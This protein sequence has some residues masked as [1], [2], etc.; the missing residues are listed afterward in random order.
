[1]E[2]DPYLVSALTTAAHASMAEASMLGR[3]GKLAE[4]QQVLT[5][6]GSWLT[7]RY[8]LYEK[9]RDVDPGTLQ[10]LQGFARMFSAEAHSERMRWHTVAGQTAPA[11]QEKKLAEENFE[12]AWQFLQRDSVN[13]WEFLIRRAAHRIQTQTFQE[14]LEDL[15]ITTQ[16]NNLSVPAHMWHAHARGAR[17]LVEIAL[18][19]AD[20][21][22]AAGWSRKGVDVVKNGEAWKS[23]EFPQDQWLEGV[24]VL[25][26]ACEVETTLEAV[27]PLRGLLDWYV[28]Q[29]A[30]DAPPPYQA[31]EVTK[32]KVLTAQAALAVVDARLA[33]LQKKEAEATAALAKAETA[34]REAIGL[35]EEAAKAGGLLPGAFAYHV[36]GDV[37]RLQGKAAEAAATDKLAWGASARNPE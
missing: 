16:T 31:P 28:K 3:S 2:K 15:A 8:A 24:R 13:Y 35:R 17:L 25:A 27:R 36:L 12:F 22:A 26:L 18:A 5:E 30:Q 33:R 21:R 14:A 20:A 6:V 29:A 4:A 34:V 23:A 19:K 37:Q 11:A 7:A 9:A 1:M 32:A 10:K